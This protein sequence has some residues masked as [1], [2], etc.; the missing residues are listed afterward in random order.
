MKVEIP[1]EIIDRLHKYCV[2]QMGAGYIL[3]S[4]EFLIADILKKYLEVKRY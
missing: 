1:D 3:P 4:R 2:A